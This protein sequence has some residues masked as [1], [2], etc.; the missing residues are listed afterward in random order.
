MVDKYRLLT[1]G[2]GNRP[3]LNIGSPLLGTIVTCTL[4]QQ[5]VEKG[6]VYVFAVLLGQ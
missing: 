4:F 1:I 5:Y 6:V 2:I 3:F